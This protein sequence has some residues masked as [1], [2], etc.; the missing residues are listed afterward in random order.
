[1]KRLPIGIQ[2]FSE[3]RQRNDLYVDKTELIYNVITGTKIN[4]LSRPRRFGKSLTISTIK[5][6]YEGEKQYFDGLWIEDK[7]D[8]TKRNPVIHLQFASMGFDSNG[9]EEA[10]LRVCQNHATQWGFTLKS[11][12]YVWAFDELIK[13]AAEKIG[14]VVIL[15]DEY[16]KPIID[17]LE[18]INHKKAEANR[19]ILRQFYS[20]IKD[21]DPYI[22]L[23]FMTGVSKFSQ[24]GVFSHLNHLKDLTLNDNFVN[25]VGYTPKELTHYFEDW[26]DYAWKKFPDLTKEAF[27]DLIK[28]WYNGY[29]WD[30]VQTVYNPY[31]ILLFLDSCRFDSHWF[32]TGT[33][34]FL[35]K[36]MRE[37]EAFIFN[38]LQVSN[39]LLE[40]YEIEN[41]DVRTILFQTGYL[42]VKHLDRLNG[43]YTLDYPNREVEQAMSNYILAEL[44]HT[45]YGAT[46]IPVLQ[47]KDAFAQNNVEKVVKIIN[48]I[49]KDVPNQ[50]LKGK[51]EDF[52][53][54]L[55][56]VHFRYL[57]LLM[58]SEVNT[59]DGRMDAVVRTPT[60]IY[61]LEFKLNESAE[62]AIQQ[63]IDKDYPAKYAVAG[64]EIQMVGINFNSRKKGIGSW[65]MEK[66]R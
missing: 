61:I 66:Y 49:L 3:L 63:I 15:I 2:T 35:I 4:S 50:L 42:T 23:F 39:T 26:L 44:L 36:L 10:L 14:R 41:L 56:H 21:A 7:W 40:S 1:M 30:G 17:Y 60:H 33:P 28:I 6:I 13:T 47:I 32:S 43:I 27:M 45:T 54:A 65:K 58:D 31:S 8:W 52:Y 24:T 38:Q 29:S 59:S 19:S 64:K 18:K 46:A 12:D 22:E 51:K 34:T 20:I 53:H 62:N 9:L 48:S 57:G 5:S 37:Q 11:T 25:L 16:D 55:V